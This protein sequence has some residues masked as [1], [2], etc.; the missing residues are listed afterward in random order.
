MQKYA[1]CRPKLIQSYLVKSSSLLQ[2]S[3][4]NMP[5]TL[6]KAAYP[7]KYANG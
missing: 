1:S 6:E 4:H 2:L 5:L 3:I 7:N